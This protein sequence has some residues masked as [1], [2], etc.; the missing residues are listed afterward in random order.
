M[1]Q[2]AMATA[3][4]AAGTGWATF[5]GVMFFVTGTFHVI[6]GIAALADSKYVLDRVL[7]A[8][9]DFWG[10]VLLL[11]GGLGIFAGWAILGRQENGRILGIALAGL[12][13]LA[14]LMIVN[15]NDLWSLVTIAIWMAILYA[16]IVKGD[17]YAPSPSQ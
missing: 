14:Q 10:V 11:V 2:Q 12:G 6:E 15:A 8:N 3:R 9:L 17:E 5:A 13:I 7:F 16:L 1:D 4:A